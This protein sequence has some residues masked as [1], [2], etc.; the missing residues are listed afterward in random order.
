MELKHTYFD[1]DGKETDKTDLA[2]ALHSSGKKETY[3][4]LMDMSRK[5][6]NPTNNT[7]IKEKRLGQLKWQLKNVNKEIFDGYISFLKTKNPLFLRNTERMIVK[8]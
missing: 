3:F 5:V 4:I 6:Y 2:C 1:R 8:V 7:P